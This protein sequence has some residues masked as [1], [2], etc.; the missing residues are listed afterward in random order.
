VPGQSRDSIGMTHQPADHLAVGHVPQENTAV[1]GSDGKPAA[2]EAE[3][4]RTDSQ[5]A[6]AVRWRN[7][8]ADLIGQPAARVIPEAHAAVVVPARQ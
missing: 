1:L 2:I 7:R 6:P 4:Q 8:R 5:I 3:G